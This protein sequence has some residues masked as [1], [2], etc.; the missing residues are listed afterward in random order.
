MV[1]KESIWYVRFS[2]SVACWYCPWHCGSSHHDDPQSSSIFDPSLL[3]DKIHARASEGVIFNDNF[4]DICLFGYLF[5]FRI[6]VPYVHSLDLVNRR[7]LEKVF[8]RG[9]SRLP[10]LAPDINAGTCCRERDAACLVGARGIIPAGYT[11]SMA[12]KLKCE[13]AQICIW[14]G[15]PEEAVITCTTNRNVQ[16]GN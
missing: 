14:S 10:T 5:Q 9:N 11:I 1:K 4:T 16:A 12:A 2:G 3:S 7:L 8:L 15:L 6:A 13:D